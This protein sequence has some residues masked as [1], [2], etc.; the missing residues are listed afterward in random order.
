MCI[1]A[2]VV[3]G[4][5]QLQSFEDPSVGCRHQAIVLCK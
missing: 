3:V 4:G 2:I 1:E 5:Q